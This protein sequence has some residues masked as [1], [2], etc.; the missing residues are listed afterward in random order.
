MLHGLPLPVSVEQG[1]VT[2]VYSAGEEII[3]SGT[4]TDGATTYLFVTGPGLAA[5]G[6]RLDDV[7][8]PGVTKDAGTFTRVEVELDDTWEYRWDTG[9]CG[10]PPAEAPTP[11]MPSRRPTPGTIWPMLCMELPLS[12]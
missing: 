7:A 9:T 11:S 1:A 8:I 5:N 12:H 10:L 4:N 6:V 3:F 2:I